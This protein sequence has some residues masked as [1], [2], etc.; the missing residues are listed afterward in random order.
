MGLRPW[1]TSWDWECSCFFSV[2]L[3]R[4]NGPHLMFLGPVYR[5][6]AHM[7]IARR[8]DCLHASRILAVGSCKTTNQQRMF[9]R[10]WHFRLQ[11]LTHNAQTKKKTLKNT[12]CGERCWTLSQELSCFSLSNSQM[13][14]RSIS[15]ERK[16]SR[17]VTLWKRHI[18][19]V[20]FVVSF[21]L[22]SSCPQ[23]SRATRKMFSLLLVDRSCAHL[24]LQEREKMHEIF[25]GL[26]ELKECWAE[27][28]ITVPRKTKI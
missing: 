20:S 23:R 11:N 10:L 24:H 28:L 27:N 19:E 26:I 18:C 13:V 22:E 1:S 4:R 5:F 7:M 3:Q 12:G 15:A 9:F 8:A 25:F 6:W 21:Q 16:V 17:L 2:F 14:P